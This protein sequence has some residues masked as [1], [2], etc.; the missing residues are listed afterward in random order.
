V[1]TFDQ[2]LPIFGACDHDGHCALAGQYNVP[3]VGPPEMKNWV[4]VFHVP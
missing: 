1:E 3:V 4:E 2:I